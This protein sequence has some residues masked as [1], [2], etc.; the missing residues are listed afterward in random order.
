MGGQM[1][2]KI[3]PEQGKFQQ[4]LKILTKLYIR[5]GGKKFTA[6][7]DVKEKLEELKETNDLSKKIDTAYEKTCPKLQHNKEQKKGSDSKKKSHTGDDPKKKG[8][9]PKKEIDDC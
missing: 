3:N 7:T 8:G 5:K 9:E 4:I 6:K 1:H 2:S